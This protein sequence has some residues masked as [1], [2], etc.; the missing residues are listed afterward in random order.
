MKKLSIKCTPENKSNMG[1]FLNAEECVYCT[2]NGYC[3]DFDG[4]THT[5]V[6]E[7]FD[8]LGKLED[9]AEQREKGCDF[10]SSQTQANPDKRRKL[11]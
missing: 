1:C 9:E 10:C 3:G 7:V 2:K 8:K 5:E 11:V 4:M 6:L